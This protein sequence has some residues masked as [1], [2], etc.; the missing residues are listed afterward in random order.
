MD[1]VES[2]REEKTGKL[3]EKWSLL[4]CNNPRVNNPKGI[5]QNELQKNLTGFRKLSSPVRGLGGGG[6]LIKSIFGY[7]CN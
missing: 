4:K 3:C 1:K 7:Y 5:H 6:G 2:I